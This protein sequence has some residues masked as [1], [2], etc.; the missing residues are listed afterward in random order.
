MEDA[1]EVVSVLFAS[2]SIIISGRHD[3]CNDC[4]YTT[5]K[6]HR[7]N[8]HIR[9]C[10]SQIRQTLIDVHCVTIRLN[11]IPYCQNLTNVNFVITKLK[12]HNCNSHTY[13]CQQI[14]EN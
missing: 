10:V 6:L 9:K 7:C 13:K 8:D 4:G 2:R 12:N 3:L 5:M 14:S 1:C 11:L